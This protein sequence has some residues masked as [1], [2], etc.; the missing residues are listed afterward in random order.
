MLLLEPPALLASVVETAARDQ[1]VGA[2]GAWLLAFLVLL[3]WGRKEEGTSSPSTS[4]AL[5]FANWVEWGK[6]LTSKGSLY[7]WR[8]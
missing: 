5:H 7:T 8:N 4:C 1:G 2:T 6:A 3:R